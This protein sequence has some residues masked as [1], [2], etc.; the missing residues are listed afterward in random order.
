[1]KKVKVIEVGA[2][3]FEENEKI[4]EENRLLLS[5]ANTFAVNIMGSP[6]SGKTSLLEKTISELK[7]RFSFAVI[8]GDIKG[9][10]DAERVAKL[11]IPVIQINTGGAC[12]LDAFMVKKGLESLPLKDI[13]IIFVENVGNLVCPA[14]FEIGTS[15]NIVVSSIP[16]GEDKP[17]KYPLMFKIADICILNKIDLLSHTAFDLD[18][19]KKHLKDISSSQFIPLSVKTGEGFSLWI[20]ALSES[21]F[22]QLTVPQETISVEWKGRVVIVGMGDRMKADDGA[23]SIIAEKLT[24]VVKRKDVKVIDAGNSIENYFGVIERFKPDTIVVIDAV[25]FGG[26]PGEIRTLEYEELQELTTSTHSFSLH[27]L[28]HHIHN[29]TGANCIVIGVQPKDLIL[30]DKVSQ[31]VKEAIQKLTEIITYELCR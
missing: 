29:Q 18:A 3:I 20:E 9:S 17:L 2:S 8:E 12:H 11:D 26:E 6:G 22:R 7:D 23:G 4:A 13:D 21:A 1:M 25:D 27:L 5:K 24:K 28:L 10:L 30:S 15:F 14:E 31:Q 16:E 19:F